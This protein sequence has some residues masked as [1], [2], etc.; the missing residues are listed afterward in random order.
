MGVVP[1]RLCYPME[2]AIKLPVSP[3]INKV[4]RNDIKVFEHNY[5]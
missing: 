5:N 2:L 1:G 3:S 4:D